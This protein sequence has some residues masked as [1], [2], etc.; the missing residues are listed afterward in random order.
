MLDSEALEISIEGEQAQ[1]VTELFHQDIQRHLLDYPILRIGLFSCPYSDDAKIRIIIEPSMR[2]HRFS[3]AVIALCLPLIWTARIRTQTQPSAAFQAPR[4]ATP[5]GSS[6]CASCHQDVHAE[7]KS[8]RHSKMIQPANAASVEGDFSQAR[9]TLRGQPFQ[10]RVANGVYFITESN[11][12]GTPREHRVEYTLGSRR[13]QHYLTTIENGRIIVLTP[14]WDV[15]RRAWFDNMEIVRPDEDD[16]TPVQQWNKNCVGCHVSQQDNHYQP[17]T[18][19]YATAFS[20]F[21]TSCERCHGPGNAHVAQYRTGHGGIAAIDRA[22]VRPTRLDPSTSSMICA[23]CHS[24]RD[25][26]GPGYTAGAN[27]FDHFQPILEYG[28]R[29]ESDPAY[30]A[31]GR[32]RRFSN[33]AMGLWQSACYLRGGATCTNC[34]RDPHLPDVDKNPQL[35]SGAS[36]ALCTGCHKAIG[37]AVTTHTRHL[38]GSAGSSCVEC[39]MPKTVLSIKARIRDHSMSLPAPENTVRFAIPNACNECHTDKPATWAVDTLAAWWPNGRRTALVERADAFSGGRAARPE[40]LDRLIA[41]ARTDASGPLVQ[42]NA[43]GY[44]ANYP[45][46]RA[47]AALFT[48]AKNDQPAI[49]SAAL[50]GLG[51]VKGGE[52]ARRA[53]LLAALGDPVRAVRIAALTG[54]INLGG[55]PPDGDDATRFRGVTLEFAAR[56]RLHEDDAAMQR[57]LGLVRMLAGDL[58]Q[59]AAA[60]Q[61]A[62]DLEADRPSVRFLLGMVRFGQRRQEEATALF[63]QVK[64][65]DPYYA[66]AQAQLK[67]LR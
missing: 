43:V 44:L 54:L 41:L 65:S 6:V 39:H 9:I 58:D 30:W 50:S 25:I 24:L 64:A 34:H 31:D 47:L 66:A 33:D 46:G 40:A 8:G 21:G 2:K 1:R 11:I 22:I 29:K 27:Y 17:A 23:Q 5:L 19:T 53:V 45:D 48:A 61:I 15:E 60:L 13:I 7:W 20:D 3:A 56:A 49:R 42:A 67:K 26:I 62:M 52:A 36:D 59:A 14:S 12:T 28:P 63:R 51:S 10:L 37:A 18:H 35:A 57:D 32:P 4:D 16:R 55:P 38:A